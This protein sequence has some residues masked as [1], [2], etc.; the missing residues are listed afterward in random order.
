VTVPPANPARPVRR[1]RA[2]RPLNAD[3]TGR[4]GAPSA[5]AWTCRTTRWPSRSTPRRRRSRGS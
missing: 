1:R 4:A 5:S 2:G 3:I